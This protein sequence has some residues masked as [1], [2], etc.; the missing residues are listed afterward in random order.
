[1]INQLLGGGWVIGGMI[2]NGGISWGY[3]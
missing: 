1:M 3:H 2:S